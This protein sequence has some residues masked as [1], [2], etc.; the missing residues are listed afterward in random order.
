[1]CPGAG[2]CGGSGFAARRGGHWQTRWIWSRGEQAPENFYLYWRKA[3]PLTA[4]AV[5]ASLNVSADSRCEL[6]VNGV[7]IGRG[8]ARADQRWLYYDSYEVATHLRPGENA[9]PAIVHHYGVPTGSSPSASSI[10]VSSSRRRCRAPRECSGR[11]DSH[12]GL[13][14]HR[15]R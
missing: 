13:D 7:L 2:V 12:G 11:G 5:A 10:R 8:P 15:R 4:A 14:G 3:Y 9:I 6:H 1:M